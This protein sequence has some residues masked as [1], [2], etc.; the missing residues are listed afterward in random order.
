MSNTPLYDALV[1]H[2]SLSRASMHTPGHKCKNDYFPPDFLSFD[3]TELPDTDSLYEASGAI[4]LAEENAR[5]FF[6][7]SRT[8]FSSGG[9]TLC[10]QTMISLCCKRGSKIIS[11][12][13]IHRSAVNTMALLDINPVWI[14]PENV[15][16]SALPGR[17]ESKDIEKAILNNRDASAV[18]LTSPNYYGEI[19]DIKSISSVC[20]KYNI[21]LIVDNAHGTHLM[22]T[23]ENLHPITLGASI[24]SC[25]AHKTL[26]VLTGGAFLNIADNNYSVSAK[27]NMSLF[28]STSPSYLT[29]ASLD[30]CIDY[31][32]KR[33]KNDFS[34]LEDK[35]SEIKYMA[36]KRGIEL[37]QGLCDPVR[38][39]LNTGSIGIKGNDAGEYFR[40]KGIEP[41][42]TDDMW[43]VFIPTPFNTD[44]ELKRLYNAVK[45]I[46]INK[47]VKYD[48]PKI[49][50]PKQI[51]TPS[52]AVFADKEVIEVSNACGR[53]SA[54]SA[55]PCP[56]GIPIIMQ[57]EMITDREIKNLLNLGINNISVVAE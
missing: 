35:A 26:P 15:G 52:Q 42:F 44:E 6:G 33:G 50:L 11:G 3:F 4:A 53:I 13:N 30:L 46:P 31:M 18:Y 48:T 37:P 25:S 39:S 16:A 23:K 49:V 55:C 2:K 38:I 34:E 8:L 32:N 51:M 1:N 47:P 12:R 14:L 17:I 57:G 36:S 28:G 5:E 7:T 21:P 45:Q 9:C 29:M 24:T 19:S 56:P 40:Q 54:V 27:E 22:L 43:V 20:K 10:I 41:E